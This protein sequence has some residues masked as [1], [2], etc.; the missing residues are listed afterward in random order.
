MNARRTKIVG[1]LGPASRDEAT[2]R[3]LMRAGLDV[4]RIN[5]SHSDAISSAPLI[6]RLRA[7]AR[8]LG[9]PL[10]ILQ[11]LQGPKIRTGRLALG[12]PVELVAGQRFTIT[13]RDVAGDASRVSTSY[14]R[15]PLEAA[16]GSMVLLDDGLIQ[17]EVIQTTDDEV[18]CEVVVGGALGQNKGI[19]L[20][21]TRLRSPALTRKDRTDLEFG[22]SHEVDYVALSFVRHPGDIEEARQVIHSMDRETP[23]IAKI[24]RL[25]AME[26]LDAIL[27]AADGVM[28]ARGDLGVETSSADV[29]VLQ[30]QIIRRSG[31]F[32]KIDITA[33]QMLQSMIDHPRPTRAEACDVANAIFDGTDALM[34][35]AE[36]AIGRYPVEAVRTMAEIAVKAEAHLDEFGRRP[37]EAAA[38]TSVARATAHAACVAAHQVGAALI[39]CVTRSGRTAVLVSQQR[40]AVPIVA[41]TPEPRTYCRLALPW[42]VTPLRIDE[43]PDP[44]ALAAAAKQALTKA[45]F[46]RPGDRIALVT[47]DNLAAGGTNTMTILG[48]EAAT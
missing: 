37:P 48:I 45:Q 27:E 11:D 29:P 16:Q 36:T 3:E 6:A 21:G 1:T 38:G 8:D 4:A 39:A 35:S 17:L 33:T 20:P 7:V 5:F 40:P 23:V 19:N 2:L 42:G 41:L 13:V 28:V 26:N 46:V 43:A 22:V 15:L 32:G 25:E 34:L 9:R 31:E 47:G 18:V 10:A 24:E 14:P 44:E 12:R 30:K